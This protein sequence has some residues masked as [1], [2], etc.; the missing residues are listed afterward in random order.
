MDLAGREHAE[1]SRKQE[2]I[3][4]CELL[5]FEESRVG[6]LKLA[7]ANSIDVDCRRSY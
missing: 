6:D 4:A 5:H 2:R 7:D 3:A 1:R